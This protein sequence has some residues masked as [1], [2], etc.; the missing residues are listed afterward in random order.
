[1]KLTHLHSSTHTA[2]ENR[3]FTLVE[4]MVAVAISGIVAAVISSAYISQRRTSI[5]QEQVVEMQQNIR[6]GLDILE[7]DIRMAGYDPTKNVP[8]PKNIISA[9]INTVQISSDLNSDEDIID[10]GEN[11]TYSLYIAS[12]GIQKLGRNDNTGGLGNQAVAESIDALEFYY[13]L[14]NGTQ[15]TAPTA[16]QLNDIRAVQISIMARAGRADQDFTNTTTYTTASGVNWGPFND[17]FRRRLHI[18][19]IQCRNM[20]L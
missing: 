5:A 6:A 18:T 1:M 20:G 4:L 10:T 2:F 14:T 17:N 15:T 16:A 12:D 11:L 13:T 9:T 19:T 7:R 8:T 3:G